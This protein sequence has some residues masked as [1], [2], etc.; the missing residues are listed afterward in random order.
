MIW[1][2]PESARRFGRSPVIAWQ[3]VLDDEGLANWSEPVVEGVICSAAYAI[4][5]PDGT[6]QETD[7]GIYYDK[8]EAWLDTLPKVTV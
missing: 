1:P 7:S 3:I 2:M 5:C 4:L 6:V 8:V